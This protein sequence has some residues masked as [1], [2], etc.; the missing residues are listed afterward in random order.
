M[1]RLTRTQKF[2]DLRE[3][4]SNGKEE[5]IVSP[6]LSS[7]QDRLNNLQETLSPVKEE[8]KNVAQETRNVFEDILNGVDQPKPVVEEKP[9]Y[10]WTP[11]NG[12]TVVNPTVEQK[13]EAT[14]IEDAIIEEVNEPTVLETPVVEEIPAE[15][16]Q[17]EAVP[18]VKETPVFEEVE[19]EKPVVETVAPVQEPVVE[20]PKQESSYFDSFV[21]SNVEDTHADD[22]NS[23]FESVNSAL[24][25]M[26][27]DTQS[28][29]KDVEDES[30]EFVTNKERDTYLNQTLSD[31]N[32]Y[33]AI[34]G[35]NTINTTVDNLVDEVRHPVYDE[36]EKSGFEDLSIKEEEGGFAWKGV[37]EEPL[38]ADKL[39]P[40]PEVELNDDEFSSTVSLEITKIM[41]EIANTKEEKTIEDI[42]SEMP[43]F[44]E[45]ETTGLLKEAV[46]QANEIK[47]EVKD[48]K[49]VEIKN[50]AEMTEEPV[51]TMS[52]TIPFVVAAEDEEVLDE[53]DEEDGSNTVLNVILIVL[54]VV[55]VAVLGLIVFYI[56][57]T[58]GI[59]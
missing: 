26:S 15:Q 30:G 37:I 49:V 19:I 48:E 57:K 13:E 14:L 43:V 32:A 33:N 2:A 34:N 28:V 45:T 35:E 54:I 31:V 58:K 5:N 3:Q 4:L 53:E 29:F 59:L 47:P 24:D 25:Q 18:Q 38:D 6:T 11:F 56:L 41:D 17:V 8:V 51:N 50:I 21:N 9:E 46:E 16:P 12:E 22:Y 36:E 1:P 55:L 23:Y 52:S 40:E 27:N 10:V 42:S 7:Y 44:E 20:E 39:E